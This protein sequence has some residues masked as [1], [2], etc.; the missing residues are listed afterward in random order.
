MKTLTKDDISRFAPVRITLSPTLSVEVICEHDSD[1]EA[2]WEHCDGHGPVSDW[3]TRD[4]TP[5]ERVLSSD[6]RSK[7]FYD[8]AEA[9]KLARKD[10]WDAAPY[11]AAF[12]NET[13]GQQAVRAAEA[14]FKHLQDWCEDRWEYV[15][16]SVILRDVDGEEIARDS[17][18]AVE[19]FGD[20]W[21][22]TAAEMAN[23]L[24]SA[25]IEE[26]AE[27][28]HWEARDVETVS[29]P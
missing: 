11:H 10:G 7:R 13:A 15:I 16:L 9:V 17:L 3:T 12:P 2:P 14:D 18:G 6:R 20:Y 5:G 19:S 22:Q 21:R 26:Q 23:A 1:C 4:K 28:A 29:S 25:H 24:L 27:R 8:F